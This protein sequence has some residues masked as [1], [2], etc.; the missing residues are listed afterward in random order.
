MDRRLVISVVEVVEG[1]ARTVEAPETPG[2]IARGIDTSVIP[3]SPTLSVPP[4]YFSHLFSFSTLPPPLSS[5]IHFPFLCESVARF[6]FCILVLLCYTNISLFGYSLFSFKL[7][8]IS[9]EDI[10]FIDNHKSVSQILIFIL[11]YL[12]LFLGI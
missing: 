10:P 3:A 4:L 2:R 8:D 7:L 6:I 11:F 9:L 1:G 5:H 12:L